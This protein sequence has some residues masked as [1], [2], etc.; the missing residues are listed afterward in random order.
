MKVYYEETYGGYYDVDANTPEAAESELFCLIGEGKENGPE[1]CENSVVVPLI[2]KGNVCYQIMGGRI[3]AMSEDE[4][5][6]YLWHLLRYYYKPQ[7]IDARKKYEGDCRTV[8]M[9]N[10]LINKVDEIDELLCYEIY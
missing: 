7:L 3:D 10:S 8:D 1:Q 2:G 4:K 6:F 5:K 9:I